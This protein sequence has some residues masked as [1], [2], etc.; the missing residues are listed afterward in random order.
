M[1]NLFEKATADGIRERLQSLRQ[2]SRPVWGTM[3]AAQMVKHCARSVEWGVGDAVP[4]TAPLPL[5]ILGRVIKPLALGD[6]RPMRRNSPTVPVLRVQGE[7]EIGEGRERLC[8]LIDRFV[9]GGAE[10]CTTHRHAIF[11]KMTPDEWAVLMYNHLDHHL[12]QFEV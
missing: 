4:P 7:P 6:E 3:T 1:K 9:E 5:R 10:R 8:A 11:G 12:R 2:D